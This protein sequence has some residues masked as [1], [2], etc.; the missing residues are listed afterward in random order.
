MATT[1]AQM[2][3]LEPLSKE[4]FKAVFEKCNAPDFAK[5]SAKKICIAYQIKGQ[6]DPAYIANVISTYYSDRK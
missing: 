3:K 5:E 1:V 2:G 4:W 6:S